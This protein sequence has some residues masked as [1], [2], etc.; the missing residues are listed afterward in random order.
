MVSGQGLNP[1]PVERLGMKLGQYFKILCGS[2]V[3]NQFFR[4][5]HMQYLI[6]NNRFTLKSVIIDTFSTRAFWYAFLSAI[7]AKFFGIKYILFLHGG[8]LKSRVDKNGF[9][10]KNLLLYAH[11]VVCPS[12]FLKNLMFEL[13]P[14]KYQII[15]NMIDLS[16]F[17]PKEKKV[18]KKINILWVRALHNMYNPKM[19]IDVVKFISNQNI[20][21][22]MFMVGADKDNL[23]NDLNKYCKKNKVDQLITFT[24]RLKTSE[25][26]ELSYN[27]NFFINT[28][29]IDNT[30][31]SVVESIALGFPVI[32]TDVGGLPY[33]IENEK[34]G[35]LVEKGDYKSMAKIII[36]LKSDIT[37]YRKIQKNAI[38]YSKLYGWENVKIE[39][40]KILNNV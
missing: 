5:C 9:I 31:L 35:F 32:S 3:K 37:A 11:E 8:N 17:S 21:V 1:Q 24:G 16:Q 28:T 27:C 34:N 12:R 10:L 29:F 13:C 6:F 23:Q 26:V 18:N 14:R 30:P 7:T 22:H 4:L 39:W 20:D 36:S 19:A 40:M 2:S 33:L 38:D 15:P 25:W